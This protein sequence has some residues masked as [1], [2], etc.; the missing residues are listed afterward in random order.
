[1]TDALEGPRV[2]GPTLREQAN[3]PR[4]G[5]ARFIGNAIG[6]VLLLLLLALAAGFAGLKE[7]LQIG[8]Q[9]ASVPN[10]WVSL[11]AGILAFLCLVDLAVRRRHDRGQSG[12][13]C[14]AL[15]F[16]LLLIFGAA[17]F[18]LLASIPAV[19]IAAVGVLAGLYLLVA[20]AILPGSNGP[21]RYGPD[22]RQH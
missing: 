8:P 19:A 21:N 22:P 16:L 13:D 1:M 3:S 10:H 9:Q 12:T 7:T 6:A 14:A 15:L 18:G 4:I 17:R 2:N 5:R 20:L 11:V